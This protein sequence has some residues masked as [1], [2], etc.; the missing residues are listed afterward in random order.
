[1]KNAKPKHA[2]STLVKRHFTGPVAGMRWEDL[3][4]AIIQH[5]RLKKISVAA[6]EIGCTTDA[7][8]KS[9]GGKC[10]QVAR[11]LEELLATS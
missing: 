3:K 10:P 5:P 11:R 4:A 1:M 8:R 9:V 7:I 6:N 2:S